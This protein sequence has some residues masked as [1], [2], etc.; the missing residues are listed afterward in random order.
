MGI[1]P[2]TSRTTISRSNQLSYTR[3]MVR[4]K[5]FEPLTPGLEGRCSIR[6]SYRR[7]SLEK[8]PLFTF[9]ATIP[10]AADEYVSP[11]HLLEIISTAQKG[12]R[13]DLERVMGSTSAFATV[14][15]RRTSPFPCYT[16]RKLS[17]L[18]LRVAVKLL[19]RVMGIGPTLPAWKA[20]ILP[21]NYTRNGLPFRQ[22][23]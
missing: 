14:S 8:T 13:A 5:G 3:R 4:L 17:R 11:L 6:L 1:E 20:G 21:L 9:Y 16:H 19:E 15:F 10:Q 2:T 7:I 12:S 22:C 23:L 18:P